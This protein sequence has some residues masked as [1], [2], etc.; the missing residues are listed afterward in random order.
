MGLSPAA[1]TLNLG[2]ASMSMNHGFRSGA[3]DTDSSSFGLISGIGFCSTFTVSLSTIT[4]AFISE[5]VFDA[6]FVAMALQDERT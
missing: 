6:L 2:H 1:T 3:R 4:T 5:G